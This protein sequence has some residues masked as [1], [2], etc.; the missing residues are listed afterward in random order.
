MA[1]R[2]FPP[3]AR[4]ALVS[5]FNL[6]FVTQ[7]SDSGTIPTSA[8]A[9]ISSSSDPY[10]DGLRANAE[11]E[12]ITA[13]AQA[14]AAAAPNNAAARDLARVLAE[15]L[16]STRKRLTEHLTAPS[17]RSASTPSASAPSHSDLLANWH[18]ANARACQVILA[19]LLPTLLPQCS[20]IRYAKDLLSYLT[21]RFQSQTPVSA[22]A[23]LR[24]LTSLHLADFT[25]IAD[26]IARLNLHSCPPTAAAVTPS[27]AP[28]PLP[29]TTAAAASSRPCNTFP[30]C[31]Y[32]TRHG[33]RKG[34]PCGR[35]NHPTS[36]CFQKLTDDWFLA[37]N[38][39]RLPNRLQLYRQ[40]CQSSA[41]VA[42]AAADTSASSQSSALSVTMP[43]Q[44][45]IM[46]ASPLMDPRFAMMLAPSVNGN[47][48]LYLGPTTA[49]L[50]LPRTL[51]FVLDSD[52]TDSVFRDAGVLRFFPR[53]LS[54][55]G[56]GDTMT[57][58]CTAV[59]SLPCPA[60]PSGAVCGLYVP[61]YPLV[62]WSLLFH[63][64]PSYPRSMVSSKLLH[65][66]R[67]RQG[68][69]LVPKTQL[70]AFLGINSDCPGYLFYAPSSH[71]LIRSQ[72]IIFDETRSPFLPSPPAPPAPSL[73]WSGFDQPP[74]ISPS[75]PPI[76]PL[77]APPPAPASIAPPSYIIS[78]ASPPASSSLAPLLSSPPPSS[79]PP[80]PVPTPPPSPRLTRS[81]TRALSNFQ[82]SALFTRLSPSHDVDLLK[83]CFE[84]LFNIHP[85]SPLLCVTIGDFSNSPTLLSVD[86]G[87]IPTPQS[88][89]KTM[90]GFH[91]TEWMAA[92]I[93]ECEAFTRTHSYIESVPSPCAT[94]FKGKW[95]FRV[96]QLP[97]ELPVFK[98]R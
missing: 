24:E 78:G 42:L 67:S 44:D 74:S 87:A 23:L 41:Q 15:F 46:G 30:P 61:S 72:D 84:E 4:S 33:P 53:S 32:I 71:Q 19:C 34:Q 80:S 6:W 47:D 52:A 43:T 64:L 18:V 54:I 91:A 76:P 26:Y 48:S 79:Q 51:K 7:Q 11:I 12:R 93:A 22:I 50:S 88:Y 16:E 68:G 94:I 5:G 70:C 86:T 83:D 9:P 57:M 60:S 17:P 96:K 3:E 66:D 90:S 75:P 38:T 2:L 36:S 45:S 55:Q 20:H 37:G 27:S 69:K 58:T 10:A 62:A 14:T 92:I 31:T 97:R 59:S 73:H 49:A 89:S 56:A 95:V 77:P 40:R 29:T 81:M 13:T 65:A 82:H 85:I 28:P 8:S 98:T 35:T 39:G 25:T 63:D 21:E 1:A